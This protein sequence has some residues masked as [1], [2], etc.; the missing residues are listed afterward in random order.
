MASPLTQDYT[1][2]SVEQPVFL[3]PFFSLCNLCNLRDDLRQPCASDSR[4]NN[5]PEKS[6]SLGTGCDFERLKSGDPA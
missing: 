5:T 4:L 2:W 6:C 3:F 1:N